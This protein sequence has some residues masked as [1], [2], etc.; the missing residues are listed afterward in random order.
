[1][2]VVMVWLLLLLCD[3]ILNGMLIMDE[4]MTMIQG[5]GS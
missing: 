5:Q 2:T 4:L 1:M 3:E